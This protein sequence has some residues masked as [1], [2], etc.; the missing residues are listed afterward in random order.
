M[1]NRI[2]KESICVSDSIDALSWFEEVLFYR[3]IVNCDD[4][5]RFDGRAAVIKSRLFPLKDSVTVKAVS[6]AINKL[7]SAEL[8]TLYVFEGKPYLYLPTWDKHQQVRAKRSKYPEPSRGQISSDIKCNQMISDVPVIQ[9]LS[10]SNPKENPNTK[11][12]AREARRSHGKYKWVKLSDEEFAAL[13]AELGKAEL[14]RCIQYVD[15][16]AQGTHNR[17]G[18]RDWALT[19]RKCSRNRWGLPPLPNSRNRVV[20]RAEYEARPV[21][22]I[23][24]GELKDILEKI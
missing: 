5:G 1:P 2:I 12:N 7:A 11:E 21:E 19:I 6:D 14:A 9:S 18:W 17:N 4:Y 22:Q 8:V 20:T 23:D 15:E 13:E 10:E 16:S 24:M 3:L